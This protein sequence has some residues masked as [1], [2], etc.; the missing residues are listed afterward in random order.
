MNKQNLNL[1]TPLLRGDSNAVMSSLEHGNRLSHRERETP[2]SVS[3]E[4][5]GCS[6]IGGAGGAPT[7]RTV[8]S[9][10]TPSPLDLSLYNSKCLM[11]TFGVSERTEV[12]TGCAPQGCFVVKQKTQRLIKLKWNL[13]GVGAL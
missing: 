5:L 12:S 1:E 13:F 2:E 6:G 9:T 3:I 4:G 8:E 11:S 7:I 10:P